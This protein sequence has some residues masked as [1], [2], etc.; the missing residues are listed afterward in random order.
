MQRLFDLIASKHFDDHNSLSKISR[1]LELPMRVVKMAVRL[2]EAS[3]MRE[4]KHK[5]RKEGVENERAEGG[6]RVY[7]KQFKRQTHLYMMGLG[8]EGARRRWA[9]RVKKGLLPPFG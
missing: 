2:T 8:R 1:E 7:S 9:R 4:E 3:K 6:V 5:S